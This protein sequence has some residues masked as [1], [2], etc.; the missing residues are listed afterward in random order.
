MRKILRPASIVLTGLLF[1][2]LLYAIVAAP[3]FLTGTDSVITLFNP[4]QAAR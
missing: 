3:G 4:E 1:A 2:A